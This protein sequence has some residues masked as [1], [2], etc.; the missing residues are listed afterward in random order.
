MPFTFIA[1][2]VLLAF[3]LMTFQR[4]GRS[5]IL[6]TLF[7]TITF[8]SVSLLVAYT[9]SD[10]FT[11]EGINE[12]G[13]FHVWYGLRGAGLSEYWRLIVFSVGTLLFSVTLI[14][15]LSFRNASRPRHRATLSLAFLLAIAS[16]PLN[17]ATTNLLKLAI[18]GGT[19]TTDFSRYYRRPSITATS[20]DHPNFIFIYAEGLERTYFDETIFPGL[21]T[22]LKLLES[23]GV[24]FTDLRTVYGTHFTM[25]GIVGSICGIPLLPPSSFNSMSGVDNFLPGAVGLSDLLH[26][27]GYHLAFMGGA[28][29][30]FAG[31]GK[32]LKTHKFDEIL[33]R[34]ELEPRLTDRKYVST[35]GLYDDTLLD[36]AYSHFQNLSQQNKR[37]GLFVLTLDTHHPNGHVAKGA[38][39]V[40]YRDGS[41]PILNAVA[42]SDQLLGGF[43]RRIRASPHGK[44]TVIV[45]ASDHIALRNSA[46]DLLTKGRRRNLLLVLDPRNRSG[47]KIDRAGSVLDTG[48]SLLPFL[49][50]KGIIG[51]GRDLRNPDISDS[52]LAHIQA[53]ST[54]LSWRREISQFWEFPPFQETLSFSMDPAIVV[55]DGRTVGAPVLVQLHEDYATTLRFEFDSMWIKRLSAQIAELPKGTGF[56]FVA[57]SLDAK[58]L[59]SDPNWTVAADWVLVI[60]KAGIA[61]ISI[62]LKSG[63]KFTRTQIDGYLEGLSPKTSVN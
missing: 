11:G 24:S 61:N 39:N 17:P 30:H 8:A 20:V 34:E 23:E 25:G 10:Y 9:A 53:Q 51:L 26:S 16:F 6:A 45:I 62:P 38:E 15:W 54:L 49:G 52:E 5:I 27:D 19:E 36:L 4:S 13:L 56:V 44:N 35:W 2:I 43:V 47:A 40:R 33:G 41:N 46:I 3:A 28:S 50:Y 48:T 59:F 22:E 37:F 60:G 42:F 7:F 21:I 14:G 31:K 58:P 55:I 18:P 57:P 32:F 29:M 63:A 12:S 1:T